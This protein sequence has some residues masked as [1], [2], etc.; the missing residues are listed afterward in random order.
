M[1]KRG[2]DARMA[3]V[4]LQPVLCLPL[5]PPDDNSNQVQDLQCGS[6]AAECL[7]LR[8]QRID[9]RP[10]RP[11]VRAGDEDTFGVAGGKILPAGRSTGLEEQ[12]RALQ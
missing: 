4:I 2:L 8:P 9:G 5:R 10:G 6:A 1:R 3:A 11:G 7:R 12:G